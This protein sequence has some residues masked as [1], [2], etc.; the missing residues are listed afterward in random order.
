LKNWL[1]FEFIKHFSVYKTT[2]LKIEP[3]FY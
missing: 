2:S 3:L 1:K